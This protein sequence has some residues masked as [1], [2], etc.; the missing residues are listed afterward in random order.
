MTQS[1]EVSPEAQR[2]AEETWKS[3]IKQMVV[4]VDAA[5]ATVELTRKYPMPKEPPADFLARFAVETESAT[6]PHGN[7][8]VIYTATERDRAPERTVVYT[9]GGGFVLRMSE[10]SW[11]MCAELITET[12]VRLVIPLYP[13]APEGT[14]EVVPAMLADLVAKVI[15]DEG[16]E[17]VSLVGNSVG[18]T[19]TLAA[20]QILRDRGVP[21]PHVT[22]LIVPVLDHR[23]REPE[24]AELDA[25]DP[26]LSP[27]GCRYF[28]SLYCGDLPATDP[29]VSPI[30]G[31]NDH[32]GRLLVLSGTYDILNCQ[33]RNYA[34]M[35]PTFTGTHLDYHEAPRMIHIWATSPTPEG[36]AARE[37]IY[38]AIR[39]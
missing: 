19:I 37:T 1:V 12:A 27:A 25:L 5:K 33:A 14:G 10:A 32:L 17:Q 18:G 13:L 36:A 34:A 3:G 2:F 4:T 22:V 31:N 8:W 38:R 28:G 26:F 15:A 24:M 30:L 7:E 23:Y 39:T 35:A 20:A 11:D 9:H 6:D 29:R 21:N 16:A